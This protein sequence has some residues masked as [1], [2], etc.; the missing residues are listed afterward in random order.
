M[1]IGAHRL[2]VEH[3]RGG[4]AILVMSGAHACPQPVV[5]SRPGAV[6][7]PRA[8][9]VIDGFAGRKVLGQ[10]S[11]GAAAFDDIENGVED[12]AQ[13]S[14][15]ATAAFGLGQE[16]FEELPLCVGGIGVENGDFHRLNSAAAKVS[17]TT[18]RLMSSVL[19][20]TGSYT[21]TSTRVRAVPVAFPFGQRNALI[22]RS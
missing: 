11:P 2:A 6:A 21:L 20:Q 14:A 22:S 19:F 15:R 7:A 17:R 10:Q 8:E 13:R 1:R 12:G 9:V 4:A 16:R 5:E 3:G 18:A